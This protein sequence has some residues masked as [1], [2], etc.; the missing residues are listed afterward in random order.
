MRNVTS[1]ESRVVHGPMDKYTGIEIHEV[2][3]SYKWKTC[4]KGKQNCPE[5]SQD[6]AVMM[7]LVTFESIKSCFFYFAFVSGLGFSGLE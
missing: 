2:R 1:L 5:W 3:S 7:G 4:N 6:D